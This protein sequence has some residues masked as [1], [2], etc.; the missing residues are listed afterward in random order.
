MKLISPGKIT[1]LWIVLRVAK[2]HK[3]IHKNDLLNIAFNTSL[4]AAGLP[5]KDGYEL[6]VI[7]EFIYT[8]NDQVQITSSGKGIVELSEKDEPSLNVIRH[9]LL[10]IT[11]KYNPPWVTFA[12]RPLEER[13][14]AI[15][16]NWAEVLKVAELLQEPLSED[17]INW[18]KRLQHEVEEIETKNLKKIGDA[19]ETLTIRYEKKRLLLDRLFDLA[20]KIKWRSKES[21]DYGYDIESF[22]GG[23]ALKDK[24]SEDILMIEVKSPIHSSNNNFRF[25]LTRNEWNTAEKNST[26]YFFYLWRSIKYNNEMVYGDGPIILPATYI[27][28]F[29]PLDQNIDG[30]WMKCRIE[31][32]ID[33]VPAHCVVP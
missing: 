31:L 9:I 2:K 10:T 11:L 32:D 25:V 5:I 16:D 3:L 30:K 23:F 4:R 19:G 20:E 29:V 24:D 22:F 14:I 7:C 15:P 18:W 26:R 8:E 28:N 6:A 33:K 21:D 12:S 13:T 17:A 27:Q 1:A